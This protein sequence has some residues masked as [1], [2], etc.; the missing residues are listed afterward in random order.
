M[1]ENGAALDFDQANI[2]AIIREAGGLG[3]CM[4]DNGGIS[5][6]NRYKKFGK[7][8]RRLRLGNW[9][10]PRLCTWV[11]FGREYNRF[12]AIDTFQTRPM[13]RNPFICTKTDSSTYS[14]S[15]HLL[16]IIIQYP[17]FPS[18]Q[19]RNIPRVVISQ[20]D[21]RSTL[22]NNRRVC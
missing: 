1:L 7:E 11:T 14:P 3:Y 13:V 15:Y 16:F 8:R 21:L 5:N 22:R 19:S 17:F 20:I 9:G 10:S 12:P 4:A 2:S 6:E 18:G